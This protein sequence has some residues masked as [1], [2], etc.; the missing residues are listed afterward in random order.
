VRLGEVEGVPTYGWMGAKGRRSQR[1]L[2]VMAEIP[3]GWRGTADIAAGNGLIRIAERGNG[4]ILTLKA[5]QA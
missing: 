2:I 3:R 4:R 5:A 1:Y